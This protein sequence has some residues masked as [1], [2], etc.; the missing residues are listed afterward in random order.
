MSAPVFLPDRTLSA[1]AALCTLVSLC[2]LP[3]IRPRVRTGL[4]SSLHV[5]QL[6]DSSQARCS[7][8]GISGNGLCFVA[9]Q[10]DSFGE[11]SISRNWKQEVSPHLDRS[12]FVGET[13]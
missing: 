12:I 6:R 5:D 2:F 13:F 9:D 10:G 11:Q 8:N 4:S 7:G 3:P 1:R